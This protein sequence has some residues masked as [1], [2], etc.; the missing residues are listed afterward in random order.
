MACVESRSDGNIRARAYVCEG[1]GR[2]AS[3]EQL[4]PD[5]CK[6]IRIVRVLERRTRRAVQVKLAGGA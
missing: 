5:Q 3:V 6:G 1:H 4:H 2:F